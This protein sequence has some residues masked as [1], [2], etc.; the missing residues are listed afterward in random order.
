MDDVVQV[1]TKDNVPF[2]RMTSTLDPLQVDPRL[3]T[4]ILNVPPHEP[5]IL[6]GGGGLVVNQIRE[7]RPEP[8][9]GEP[10]VTAAMA[11][12]TQQRRSEAIV[13]QLKAVVTAGASSVRYNKAYKPA[14]PPPAAAAA[15][16]KT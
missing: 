3:M 7:E 2:Q 10:A 5:F 12:V 16:P 8:L 15:R 14:A 11:I 4:A 13:R 1:L 9:T 6:P